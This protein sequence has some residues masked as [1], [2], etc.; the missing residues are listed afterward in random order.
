M[1]QPQKWTAVQ[2][3]EQMPSVFVPEAAQQVTATYQLELS[4][5]GGGIYWLKVA[6]GQATSGEGKVE[7][8]TVSMKASAED[9]V[10]I[11]TGQ[12]NP[13]TAVMSGKLRIRGDMVLATKLS[14]MFGKPS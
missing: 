10:R 5:E 7:S 3:I 8:P 12:L 4:G 11:T 9:F 14:S 1:A 13:V 2:I 6:D